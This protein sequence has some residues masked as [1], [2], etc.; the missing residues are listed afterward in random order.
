MKPKNIEDMYPLSP[1]Q[2]GMLFHARYA[3]DSALYFVQWAT[4]LRG[5]LNG[6]AFQEAWQ[7]AIDRHPALRTLFIWE[8]LDAPLQVVRQQA[9]ARWVELDWRHLAEG[10]QQEELAA[11]LAA[12][13]SCGF[14]LSRAPLLRFHLIRLGDNTVQFVWSFHHLLLDGWAIAL[15]LKEVFAQ[16]TAL[17][18]GAAFEPAPARPY[19]EYIAWLQHRDLAQA[20]RFWRTALR[21]FTAPTPFIGDQARQGSAGIGEHG[22]RYDALPAADT[23]RLQS[24]ARVHQLTI[25]T[26]VH[27]AWA[28][29]LSRYSGEEDVV[30]GSVVAGRPVEL[31]GA[32]T[33]IGLFLN[34]LPVRVRIERD[35]VVLSWLQAFQAQQVEARQYEY[36]P[37]AQVQGWSE[38]D[39]GMPLFE[40]LL[41][42]EN[43]PAESLAL[44]GPKLQVYGGRAIERTNYPLNLSVMP[45]DELSLKLIYNTRR[46][47]AATIERLAGHFK[48][49]L[50]SI[51]AD[52]SQRLADVVL[53][54][55]GERRQLLV[56]WN[57][58]TTDC[59]RDHCLHELFEAQVVQTPDAIAAVFGDQQLTYRE[60][61]R[62][63]NQL[64]QHLRHLGV[65]PEAL[66]G[67]CVERSLD[68]LVGLLGILKAGGAYVPLDPAYP[69]ER[70]AFMLEDAQVAALVTQ[71]DLLSRLPWDSAGISRRAVVCLDR[72]RA[73]IAAAPAENLA[74]GATPAN[75][76]YVIYTSGSTGRPKGAQVEHRGIGNLAA[77]QVRAFGISLDSHILQF[78]SLSF[79][80][81]LFEIV[82]ALLSGA[83]LY[84]A[85]QE[86]LL[87]GPA[88]IQLLRDHAITTLTIS[89]SVLAALPMEE[90][91]A[92]RTIIVAGEACP[93]E[94]AARWA[95]GR[96]FFNAY[97][98][99]ETTV[100][101]TIYECTDSQRLP[102][103]R[104]IANTTVYLLDDRLQPVPVG[105]PGDLYIGGIG[106]ARGYLN[107]PE[108]TAERF[109]PNPFASVENKEQRTEN[110]AQATCNLQS[111]ICN[112]LYRTGDLARYLPDGNIE[113]LG[114]ADHQV[115]LRGFRIEL[116]E[117][118]AA[119]LRHT[120]VREAVVL[121]RASDETAARRPHSAAHAGIHNDLEQDVALPD[122]R[123]VA[124]VIPRTA[125]DNQAAGDQVGLWPSVADLKAHLRKSLPKYMIPAAIV[126]LDAMPLTP[127]GK[128]DR[129][130]LPAPSA[131]RPDLTQAFV[132]PQTAVEQSI[133]ALWR[134][135][136]Q[137]EQIGLY[138]NF[139]DLGGHSLL[140]AQVHSKI[141]RMF[142]SDLSLVDMFK[143]STVHLLARRIS[144]A[145]AE[146]LHAAFND[147]REAQSKAG[148]SRMQQRRASQ[149][150]ASQ[151]CDV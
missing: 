144:Q 131:V 124:Y 75:L 50:Q 73:S 19:R 107:Q 128:L 123:L 112:R 39:H 93:P 4:V 139:F 150:R 94:L 61:N 12:D 20:E 16:Y 56:G 70:L 58:T 13:Q 62:R 79:D 122:Q 24:F 38:V 45:G 42:F 113:Y 31:A 33:T 81:S 49:L 14:D 11:L 119:L 9:R 59:P 37:L 151:Q 57:T 2:Q 125:P 120:A 6:P 130:A 145:P 135:V 117:I 47:D 99:T 3:P 64:A 80:A 69:A 67:L 110:N 1:M 97:G 103:G 21:G 82:M 74:S 137:T 90:L 43:Y 147:D 140:L 65:G 54:T 15:I 52:P 116:G 108:L 98:P 91:P 87:P 7:A 32:E 118:E 132:T 106:L 48:T 92:L 8:G 146:Q 142:D 30:F 109:V 104:P 10:V 36:S 28:L 95:P 85:P 22:E 23:A 35:A 63:A 44:G 102:I 84:L 29:L 127:N 68:M 101:A 77:A 114:R 83:T 121:M 18:H 141:R 143:Y 72:D 111:A 126:A 46:F 60:L 89:P 5:D 41:S 76:A 100:W 34:T 115:K 149:R 138:D 88:L 136:L 53:L 129:A 134:E 86:V 17:C 148:R 71:E 133:A 55:E 40:S 96:Q 25:S 105:V 78:S 26:L 51:A 66:V 27:G